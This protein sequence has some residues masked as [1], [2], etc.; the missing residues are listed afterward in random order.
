VDKGN[1]TIILNTEDY[2]HKVT[3]LLEDT[4]YRR[5]DKDPTEKTERKTS[6]LLKNSTLTEDI[7]K[8]LLPS[9]S[10]PPRL[11]GLPKMHKD[12]VP[13]RPIVRNIGAPTYQLSKYLAG[14]LSQLTGK[15]THH[16][17]N[18][19][20]FVQTWDSIIVQPEELMVS[21]DV[22]SLFTKVPITDTLQL[23]GQHFEED[24]LVLFKHML[25]ST[26]FC[27]KGKFYEQTNGVAMGSPLSP[28]VA[29]FFMEDFEKRAIELAT[30]KPTCC[31]RYVD[32]TLVIWPHG[33]EN[34]QNSSTIS[35]D[36]ITT[37]SS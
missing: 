25:T 1:A 5:I 10:I 35:V 13:L 11:Y 14:F 24:L 27:F 34:L 33:Q 32:D 12:G 9:G 30:H 6:W 2:K 26:Y 7:N 3:S 20:Q 15:V 29:N 4:S 8:Q 18:S 22:V 23:V 28:V 37:Y 36:C 16:V 21:F 17:R 19:L 31:F